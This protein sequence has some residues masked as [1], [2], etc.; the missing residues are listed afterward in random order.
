MPLVLSL[1]ASAPALGLTPHLVKDINPTSVPGSSNPRRYVTVGGLTFF[2]ADDG[3]SG[4]ELWRTDGTAAGTFQVV[5]ACPG[6]CSS[7]PSFVARTERSY[8]FGL[9]AQDP[10]SHSNFPTELWVTDGLPSHTFQLARGRMPRSGPWRLWIATQGLLYFTIDDGIHGMELWRSDG[11]P[12][13]TFLVADVR[14]GPA[15]SN[16]DELTELNGRLFFQADDGVQ[17]PAL[18]TSDGTARGTRLVRDPVPGSAFHPGPQLL[19]T[20]GRKLFFAAP[21]P[22]RGVQLWKSDGT[23]RGTVSLTNLRSPQFTHIIRDATVLGNR[24]LFLI[25]DLAKGQELWASDGTSRGTQE[26]TR[27]TP[28]NSADYVLVYLPRVPL[29]NRMIFQAD[30]GVHGFEPWITDGTRQG[31][32]LIQD[33]CPGA[34]WGGLDISNAV[35]GNLLFFVGNDGVHGGEL[36]T[37]DGTAAGTH[38]FQDLCPGSCSSSPAHFNPAQG[39][40]FFFALGS[41]NL[42]QL[43]RTDGTGQG[44]VYLTDVQTLFTIGD[45]FPGSSLGGSF[46]FTNQD[47]EHGLELWRSDGTPQGTGLLADLN[48]SDTGGSA[49]SSLYAAGGKL[50]FVTDNGLRRRAYAGGATVSPRY[51]SNGSYP[52]QEWRRAKPSSMQK[53]ARRHSAGRT[54]MPRAR[55][56]W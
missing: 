7:H 1:L 37:T 44:T 13:G 29:G 9:Y 31:T 43:W 33:V 6:E 5:D 56:V 3:E 24:L 38:M 35:T 50:Y 11:T 45:R 55:R 25:Y 46:L 30:D 20:I 19:R 4:R 54:E 41:D 26:L 51:L 8:F 10:P 21:V 39:K 23:A 34:C 49:P 42:Y 18:W 17:G 12:A 2:S 16:P 28:I 32:R 40:I 14:P 48:T 36:W 47:P 15:G 53:V 22:R 52:G 27:V